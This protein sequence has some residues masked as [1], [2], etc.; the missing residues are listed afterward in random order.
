MQKQA[1]EDIEAVEK[2]EPAVLSGSKEA[3]AKPESKGKL[4]LSVGAKVAAV[5]GFCIAL[6][7]GVAAT[8][9]LQMQK[10]GVEIVG[11]AE[12]NIPLTDAVSKIAL[13]QTEQAVYYERSIKYGAVMAET[14]SV[15]KQ[16]DTAVR[17]FEGLSTKVGKEIQAGEVSYSPEI[18]Q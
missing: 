5:V 3:P 18:G 6:M 12:H 15:R 8:G 10:I 14:P 16:F 7:F 4:S 2:S 13:H 9:V 17:K 1:I 11:I